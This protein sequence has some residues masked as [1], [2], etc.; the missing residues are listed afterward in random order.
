[1]HINI[2]SDDCIYGLSQKGQQ[3]YY[4]EVISTRI[5][6]GKQAITDG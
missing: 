5:T 4:R 2:Y 6:T 1:M 3:T